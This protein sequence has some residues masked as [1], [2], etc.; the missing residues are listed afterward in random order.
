VY[1]TERSACSVSRVHASGDIESIAS[2]ENWPMRVI[3]D[4]RA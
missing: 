4:D 2:D 3:A 1:W